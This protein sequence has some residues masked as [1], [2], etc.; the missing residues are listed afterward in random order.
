MSVSA[1]NRNI[2]SAVADGRLTPAELALITSDERGLLSAATSVGT[3]L[4]ADEHAAISSLLGRIDRDEIV[5][6]DDTQATLRDYLASGPE[7]RL[8]HAFTGGSIGKEFSKVLGGTGA[9]TG[10]AISWMLNPSRSATL[11]RAVVAA[12]LAADVALVAGAGA[13]AGYVA[14]VALGLVED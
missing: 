12:H 8:A 7:G 3:R 5:A 1:V 13:L 9:L 6:S 11:G 2:S 4:D 14:G 10:G